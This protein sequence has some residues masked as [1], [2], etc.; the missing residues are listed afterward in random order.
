MKQ[1]VQILDFR[2]CNPEGPHWRCKCGRRMGYLSQSLFHGLKISAMLLVRLLH[3]YITVDL[4]VQC[5]VTDLV[6]HCGCCKEQ[7]LHFLA[8]MRE[9]EAHA[10]R[11]WASE[12]RLRGDIEVDA[13]AFGKFYISKKCTAFRAQIDEIQSRRRQQGE[14]DAKAFVVTLQVLG[15]MERN[16]STL[17]HLSDPRVPRLVCIL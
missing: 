17:L 12:V 3:L 1:V 10:G 4:Q 9:A 16:G 14:R 15:A 11:Q 13:T 2:S 5:K 8:I 7:A 6:A